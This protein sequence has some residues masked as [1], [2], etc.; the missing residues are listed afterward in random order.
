MDIFTLTMLLLAS[1]LGSSLNAVAGGGGFI[2][3][4]SLIFSNI[5]NLNANG[6][7]TVALWP[8]NIT[9]AVAYRKDIEL[10]RKLILYFVMSISLGG[11]VGAYLFLNT[12]STLFSIFVPFFLLFTWL[13]FVFSKTIRNYFS[14]YLTDLHF[15]TPNYFHIVFMFFIGIYGGYFGAGLGMIILTAF[16]L[17]GL[18]K[19]NE[20]NGIKVILVSFNNG[21]A[22]LTYIFSGIVIWQYT[23]VMIIGALIGGF[24]GAKL[25]RQINQNFLHNFVIVIGAIITL[26]FF[27]KQYFIK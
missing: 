19:L 9:S 6:I 13:L 16:S 2:T 21:I 24:Y 14:S 17:L 11:F 4:P 7:S 25:T 27:Y 10:S 3:Y 23:L 20:M 1:I 18:K 22:A 5:P 15:I 26:I 12:S 8:G